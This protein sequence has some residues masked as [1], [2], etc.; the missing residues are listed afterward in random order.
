MTRACLSRGI[1][2]ITVNRTDSH[3]RKIYLSPTRSPNESVTRPSARLS[4][5]HVSHAR[6]VFVTHMLTYYGSN[7][8]IFVLFWLLPPLHLF[9]GEGKKQARVRLATPRLLTPLRHII[10]G[11][12]ER[13]SPSLSSERDPLLIIHTSFPTCIRSC[14]WSN[15]QLPSSSVVVKFKFEWSVVASSVN[16]RRQDQLKTKRE[17]KETYYSTNFPFLWV[18]ETVDDSNAQVQ[19]VVVINKLQTKKGYSFL[20]LFRHLIHLHPLPSFS[21][22]LFV[23]FWLFSKTFHV[24]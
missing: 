24:L 20:S 8:L 1:Y 12:R 22:L 19:F 14:C 6:W 10:F 9:V 21:F 16:I 2:R 18:C 7:R 4:Q 13:G 5:Y 11:G 3:N 17:K 15:S 23:A